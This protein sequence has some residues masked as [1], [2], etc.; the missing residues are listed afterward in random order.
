MGP[1]ATAGSAK[2]TGPGAVSS[3]ITLVSGT[4]DFGLNLGAGAGDTASSSDAA[5][6]VG[7]GTFGCGG[8]SPAVVSIGNLDGIGSKVGE[9]LSLMGH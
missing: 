9:T 2:V 3:C 4:K 6:I 7:S 1:Q 5:E 8:A